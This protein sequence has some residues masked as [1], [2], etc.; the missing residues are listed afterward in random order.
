[1]SDI[2]AGFAGPRR[3][4]SALSVAAATA[5][6]MTLDA[7]AATFKHIDHS[8]FSLS[9]SPAGV[10]YA[11]MINKVEADPRVKKVTLDD[12][13]TTAS[14]QSQGRYPLCHDTNL[15]AELR[16]TGFCWNAAD[17][18]SGEWVPQG[19][20]G[21]GDAAA[22]GTVGGRR[23]IAA[24]WH[25]TDDKFARVSIAD[26]SKPSKG[27]GYHHLLLVQPT[28]D[29]N[30]ASVENVHADG[31]TWV[32]NRLFLATGSRLQVYDLGHIWKT[33]TGG[34]HAAKVGLVADGA[35]ARWHGWALPMVAEY[36]TAWA[37]GGKWKS[38]A[39]AT[40][41][42]PC[43]NSI[44]LAPDRKSLVTAEFY[45]AKAG[46]GRVVRWALDAATGLPTGKATEAF[47]SPVWRQQGIATDGK[48]FYVS[49][50]CPG[51][52]PPNDVNNHICI[53]KAQ[54]DA[55]PHVLTKAP[56]LT[57]N[58]AYWP[59]TGELWGLNERI[60]SKGGKR[61]VFNIKP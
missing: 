43:L 36:R 19:I 7:R 27:V 34:G 22:G 30:F 56:P 58:L 59:R 51:A 33:Q 38:C 12:V 24:S 37:A 35:Y 57:Q 41:S 45:N 11:A 39:P 46:G 21:S 55:A 8:S 26:F 10:D 20:T 54:P 44:S 23:L 15:K 61:V 13:I 14:P 16:P 47:A 6:A 50:D 4:F 3:L 29:G 60:S 25:Y 5:T 42:T 52:P 53:H 18:T 17:D 2:M 31:L 40:G 9:K 49:G 48:A 32:G 28:A 1:M